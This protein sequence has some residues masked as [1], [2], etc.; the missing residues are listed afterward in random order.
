MQNT[1]KRANRIV[2][3]LLLGRRCEKGFDFQLV[4]YPLIGLYSEFGAYSLCKSG[5]FVDLSTR[6]T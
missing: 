3:L 4:G 5:G 2:F 1:T 6:L